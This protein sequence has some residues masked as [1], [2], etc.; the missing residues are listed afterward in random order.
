MQYIDFCFIEPTI[1]LLRYLLT[2]VTEQT[3]TSPAP[4]DY[5]GTIHC[6]SLEF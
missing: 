5:H 2:V 4:W 1:S 3:T 6:L